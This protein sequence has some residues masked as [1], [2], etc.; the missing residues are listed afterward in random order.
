ML[1]SSREVEPQIAAEA[2][3][4]TASSCDSG[5][6]GRASQRTVQATTLAVSFSGNDT[7]VGFVISLLQAGFPTEE[8]ESGQGRERRVPAFTGLTLP[9]RRA[10]SHATGT[11]NPKECVGRSGQVAGREVSGD[12]CR[13]N[14]M[15]KETG[16]PGLRGAGSW[17]AG[18]PHTRPI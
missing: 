17:G 2:W 8:R 16:P 9:Y 11:G 7:L 6:V 3:S 14:G 5:P 15:H 13:G 4:G 12:L 1:S 18:Y 10:Q